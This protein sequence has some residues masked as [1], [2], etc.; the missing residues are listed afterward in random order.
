[1]GAQSREALLLRGEIEGL[2][3]QTAYITGAS[4]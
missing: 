1:M 2:R 4:S 3:K